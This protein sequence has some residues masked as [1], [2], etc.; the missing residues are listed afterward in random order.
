[1]VGWVFAILAMMSSMVWSFSAFWRVL[2]CFTT[3]K[4]PVTS[5]DTRWCMLP[6]ILA[7]S[8]SASCTSRFSS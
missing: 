3:A 2:S 8:S 6:R 5:R 4:L 1:M 7:A